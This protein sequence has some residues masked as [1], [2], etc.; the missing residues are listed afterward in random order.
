MDNGESIDVFDRNGNFHPSLYFT[1]EMKRNLGI[2]SF[3]LEVAF[4]PKRPKPK[5]L[6][7]SFSSSPHTLGDR[8]ISH[9]IYV[10]PSDK[11]SIK[12]RDIF[13][14]NLIRHESGS[15]AHR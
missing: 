6:A 1:E 11:F 9:G 7:V 10:T 5:I 2:S 15:E 8:L 12:F 3:P 14:N 13:Y 4:N